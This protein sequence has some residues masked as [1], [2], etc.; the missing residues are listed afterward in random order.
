AEGVR[1]G[2]TTV[3][4]FHRSSSC[5]ERALPEVVTAA[6]K[7]GVRVATCYGA[8]E[9][10]SPDLRRAALEESAGFARDLARKRHGRHC[11]LVGARATSL[12]GVETLMRDSLDAAGDSVGVHL[13]LA[14]DT[15]P[16]ERWRGGIWPPGAMP[17]LWAHADCA[18][19]ALLGAVV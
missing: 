12:A 6:G 4:D 8:D 17:S 18:P 9:H 10:D 15:T 19:R 3:C 11:G 5:L 7:V 14:L 2:V 1:H 16:A 13:E